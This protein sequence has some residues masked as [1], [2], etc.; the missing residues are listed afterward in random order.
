M[1]AY[2]NCINKKFGKL[3]VIGEVKKGINYYGICVCECGE[4]IV[5][6]K[7]DLRRGHTKSC[8]CSRKGINIAEKNGQWKGEDVGYN[9]LHSWVKKRLPKTKLCE[10]C[11]K[12]PPYDLANKGIY[13]RD[14]KNWEWLCRKCHMIKDGRIKNLKQN[15]I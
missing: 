5:V 2:I 6:L 11:K 15:L 4:K 13:D 14:L 10:C 8:G 7:N 9:Q 3:S 1:P 12:V